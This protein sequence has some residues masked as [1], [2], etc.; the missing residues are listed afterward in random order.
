MWEA[1]S[2]LST[3]GNWVVTSI[4][5]LIYAFEA[6]LAA[7]QPHDLPPLS[8]PLSPPGV[9]PGASPAEVSLERGLFE[10]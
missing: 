4:P 8:L 10:L 7:G 1:V 3:T 5:R 6:A 9:P 2:E